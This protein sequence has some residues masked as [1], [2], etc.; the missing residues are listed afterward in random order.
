MC[1]KIFQYLDIEYDVDSINLDIIENRASIPKSIYLQKLLYKDYMIKRF[2][3]HILPVRLGLKLKQYFA[4][5]NMKQINEHNKNKAI[6]LVDNKFLYINDDITKKL[7]EI[8]D[9]DLSDWYCLK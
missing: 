8:T 6:D 1:E 3:K 9:L 7:E 2:L 4:K 5:I